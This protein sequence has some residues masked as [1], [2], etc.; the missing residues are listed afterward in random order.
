MG[1]RHTAVIRRDITVL[2]RNCYAAAAVKHNLRSTSQIFAFDSWISHYRLQARIRPG[3][4]SPAMRQSPMER[5]MAIANSTVNHERYHE[6]TCIRRHRRFA[7]LVNRLEVSNRSSHN[8]V[9]RFA[10]LPCSVKLARKVERLLL[11]RVIDWQPRT[12]SEAE[13]KTI[14]LAAV[15]IAQPG[16]LTKNDIA[17][18]RVTLRTRRI[19]R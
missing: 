12:Y 15:I 19:G 10:V 9:L 4:N 14:Y 6:P 1:A 5:R 13:V 2:L 18:A 11:R 7:G 17:R 8:V 16:S 3:S